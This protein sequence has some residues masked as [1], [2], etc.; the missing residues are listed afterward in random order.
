M[1]VFSQY[2][3]VINDGKYGI[4][5]TTYMARYK[6]LF[7]VMSHSLHGYY[8]NVLERKDCFSFYCRIKVKELES[9][10]FHNKSCE[11][12]GFTH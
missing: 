9:L 3:N 5:I 12:I 11:I 4:S 10:I 6:T 8:G 1:C 7:D 2:N